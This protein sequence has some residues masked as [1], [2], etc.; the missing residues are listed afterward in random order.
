MKG[1]SRSTSILV[2]GPWHGAWCWYKITARL[3][4]AGH[5]VLVPDRPGHGRDRRPPGGITLQ[6]T[7]AT[8]TGL[9]DAAPEPAVLVVH[10]R[11]G[12]VAALA[13]EARLEKLRTLVYLAACLP[14]VGDTVPLAQS[15]GPGAWAHDPDSLLWARQ[16]VDV[17]R[18]AG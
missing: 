11:N 1:Q 16:S 12:I 9:L 6:D 13:A 3:E 10:S 18:D 2:H 8:L 5:R 17:D 15:R 7:V 4:A 14:P